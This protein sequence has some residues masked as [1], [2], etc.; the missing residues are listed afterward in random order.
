[1]KWRIQALIMSFGSAY[2]SYVI[3]RMKKACGQP[4][5]QPV[6]GGYIE[7]IDAIAMIGFYIGAN[8][9]LFQ[10]R[11]NRMV[12]KIP[13]RHLPDGKGNQGNPCVSVKFIRDKPGWKQ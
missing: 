3:G 6:V 2:Y 9:Y 1:M 12:D 11:K 13:G 4:G 7:H 8:V 10:V 5:K